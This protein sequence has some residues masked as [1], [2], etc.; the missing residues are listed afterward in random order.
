[1]HADEPPD[2]WS[3]LSNLTAEPSIMVTVNSDD[4]PSSAVTINRDDTTVNERSLNGSASFSGTPENSFDY[5]SS[6][7]TTDQM[8]GYI[9]VGTLA[10]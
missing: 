10:I 9:K 1:M 8:G 6:T 5:S 2:E 4:E 3:Y 7:L